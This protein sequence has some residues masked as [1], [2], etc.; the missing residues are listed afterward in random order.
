VRWTES[1]RCAFNR[2]GTQL[3]V[4]HQGKVTMFDA[5][6]GQWKWSTEVGTGESPFLTQSADGTVLAAVTDGT[7][8]RTFAA[9]S[10]AQGVEVDAAGGAFGGMA[11]SP[12]GTTLAVVKAVAG[13]RGETLELWDLKTK[14]IRHALTRDGRLNRGGF[15]FSPDGKRLAV[16]EPEHFTLFDVG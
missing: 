11:L 12:D 14:T 4:L 5:A 2:P 1:A 16:S 10:G 7:S 8:V 9:N 3:G 13:N 15:A 6:S